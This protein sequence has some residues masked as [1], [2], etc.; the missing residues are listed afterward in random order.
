MNFILMIVDRIVETHKNI[1]YIF[2]F[3]M[4]SYLCLETYNIKKEL[5]HQSLFME[6]FKEVHI[7][8]Q[9][10][11]IKKHSKYIAT[12]ELVLASKYCEELDKK[13]SFKKPCDAIY[14]YLNNNT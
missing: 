9:A 2:G 10:D 4:L 8:K 7:V 1:S 14:T 11:N 5:V 12:A 3:C 6:Q 13:R